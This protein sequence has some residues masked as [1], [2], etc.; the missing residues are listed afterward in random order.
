MDL[1]TYYRDFDPVPVQ[2]QGTLRYSNTAAMV[3]PIPA[4]V[5]VVVI[6][7][8][9]ALMWAQVAWPWLFVCAVVTFLGSAV[10][11][12]WVGPLLSSGTEI[13]LMVGLWLTEAHIQAVPV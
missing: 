13:V 7:L 4:I 1:L 2:F 10:P 8:I 9:G 5:T 6:G 3:P 12:R 11:P